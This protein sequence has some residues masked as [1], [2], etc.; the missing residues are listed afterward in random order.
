MPPTK[1]ELALAFLVL[2]T[3]PLLTE[4]ALLL[5]RVHFEPQLYIANV[6][7]GWSLRPGAEGEIAG[8][9]KQ[10]VHIN[11]HGFRDQE[12][13]YEKPADTVRIAVLGNSWTEALQVPLEKTYSS[14]LE[15]KLNDSGCYLGKRVEVLNFGVAGYST[16]QEL[17]T[18]QQE[19][20]KYQPDEILVAL[21]PA[22][23][24]VNNVKE[25]N[26]AANP[27]QSPYFVY[28]GTALILDDSFRL[29]P[30]LRP[31]HISLQKLSYD[32][33]SHV[34]LLQA[35]SALQRTGKMRLAM[36]IA[37]DRAA[38]SGFDNLEYAI[39]AEPKQPDMQVAWSVTEGLLVAIR[40]EVRAHAAA[41]RIVNLPTR[42]QLIPDSA[43]RRELVQKLGV[44]DL[45]YAE[46]RLTAFALKEGILVTN[47]SSSLS[48]YAETH[49]V[50]LNGFNS[51]S[52][53]TGH[54]N[55]T[56]HRLAAAVIAADLC[57][58]TDIAALQ[59]KTAH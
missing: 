6:D 48:S 44:T 9:N 1:K 39:Y 34:R 26:N 16:G 36:S 22:R 54:W 52:F 30:A 18:L 51:R 14:E 25:L 5:A 32:V 13:S 28:Q 24:I 21:Y 11:L 38:I 10:F 45:S 3:V 31:H 8:E 57:P 37:K 4:L 19:V 33:N 49:N 47:L 50:Y 12:R 40:N 53:G 20:W 43:R 27:E 2:L 55:E 29:T 46:N 17:L 23:D 56:G 59:A 58:G 35:I 15:R 7:R 42:P 41:L